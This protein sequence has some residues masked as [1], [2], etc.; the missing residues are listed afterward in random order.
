MG[1]TYEAL[2]VI[3]CYQERNDRILVL[4]PKRLHDNWTLWAQDNDDRNPLADDPFNYTV[5][6]HT[7]LSRYQG[8]SGDMGLEHLRWGLYDLLVID[9]SHSLRNKSTDAQKKD[10]IRVSSRTLSR[11][12]GAPRSSCCRPCQS[13]IGCLTCATRSSSSPRG[14]MPI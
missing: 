3:K 9:E 4:R 1:K 5:L 10:V 14:T 8:I 2:A 7:D 13:T 6:N 12:V 11:A